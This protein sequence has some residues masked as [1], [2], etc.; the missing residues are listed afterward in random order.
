MKADAFPVT[1][2]EHG[3][4][5]QRI[6]CVSCGAHDQNTITS[7]GRAGADMLVSFF[8]RR[9]WSVDLR[10][11]SVCPDCVKNATESRRRK[12][13]RKRMEQSSVV[14]LPTPGASSKIADVYMLLED[15]YDKARR[16]YR[17]GWSD[18]RI[19]KETGAALNLVTSRR[20]QDYG[21]IPPPKP[22]PMVEIATL[23]KP[24]LIE[25]SGVVSRAK[26]LVQEAQ[27]LDERVRRIAAVASEEPKKSA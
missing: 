26:A 4:T 24:L 3:R 18:E 20:A 25:L 17:D 5:I 8:R 21:P 1:R 19:A 27:A 9:G 15:A 22:E 7:N 14:Q 11:G 12:E 13:E 10:N 2:D 6:E 16:C 23:A